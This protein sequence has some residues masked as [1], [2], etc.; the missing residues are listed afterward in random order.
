MH[1]GHEA[2]LKIV[3][4]KTHKYPIYFDVNYLH[5]SM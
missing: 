5:I 3:L 4:E 1:S 2:L